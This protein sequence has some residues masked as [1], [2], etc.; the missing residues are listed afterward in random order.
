MFGRDT[1]LYRHK[2]GFCSYLSGI[3]WNGQCFELNR[4]QIRQV[5]IYS[6]C[7]IWCNNKGTVNNLECSVDCSLSCEG[8]DGINPQEGTTQGI[9]AGTFSNIYCG[10]I[11]MTATADRGAQNRVNWS[12]AQSLIPEFTNEALGRIPWS[13]N[14]Q[15]KLPGNK[16]RQKG[17]GRNLESEQERSEGV[18]WK[19]PKWQQTAKKEW[20]LLG[21][22]CAASRRVTS[23]W[24]LMVGL[25]GS[26]ASM[27]AA[28]ASACCCACAA[29]CCICCCCCCCGVPPR[30]PTHTQTYPTPFQSCDF[31]FQ[32][33]PLGSFWGIQ[34]NGTSTCMSFPS[35]QW[36]ESQQN[37]SCFTLWR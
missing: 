15:M 24:R 29:A 23:P 13:Q 30:W 35:W 28:A 31:F 6:C 26:D 10:I 25:A 37:S 27:P 21:A 36:W 11:F 3:Y 8:T 33:H 19:F 16:S 22:R 12:L 20:T 17:E 4:E 14:L 1:P 9:G 5:Y 18:C 32:N 2:L 34:I 7:A